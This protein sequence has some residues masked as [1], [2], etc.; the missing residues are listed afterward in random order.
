MATYEFTYKVPDELYVNSWANNST[1][2]AK[3]KLDDPVVHLYMG[4]LSV[5][6][7]GHLLGSSLDEDTP[8]YD[9]FKA[10]EDINGTASTLIT[11]DASNSDEEALAA[12]LAKFYT[13]HAH[14]NPMDADENPDDVYEETAV[15]GLLNQKYLKLTNPKPRHYWEVSIDPTD[16]SKLDFQ[17]VFK[18]DL[19]LQEQNAFLSKEE[20]RYYLDKYDLGDP[21]NADAATFMTTA[22]AYLDFM[23]PIKPW[24]DDGTLA[25]CDSVRPPKIPIHIA[26][27]IANVVDMNYIENRHGAS[28][29]NPTPQLI[30][31][32]EQMRMAGASLIERL[33]DYDKGDDIVYH[34]QLA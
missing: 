9:A 26:K 31:P 17:A 11:I 24:M 21:G 20:V 32:R 30:S 28:I 8:D 34:S 6:T 3:V 25:E 23:F 10:K 5:D 12:W 13:G 33:Y 19:T 7:V 22:K 2:T 16:I 4:H 29:D 14:G 27:E 1:A 15:P 18:S